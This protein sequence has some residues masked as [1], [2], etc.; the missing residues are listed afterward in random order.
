VPPLRCGLAH[1]GRPVRVR[2][3]DP[4][5]RRHSDPGPGYA[6]GGRHQQ[7]TV[8]RL[9][10]HARQR[11]GARRSASRR[12][13]RGQEIVIEVIDEGMGVPQALKEAMFER[14]RRGPRSQGA[15]LGLAIVRQVARGHGG[16]VGFLSEPGCHVRV[17]LPVQDF[18]DQTHLQPAAE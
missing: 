18:Q 13:D 4:N 6:I 12:S 17:V 11:D 8:A 15:G 5:F 9:R 2:E 16:D 1:A 7:S 3:D 10:M 14:F